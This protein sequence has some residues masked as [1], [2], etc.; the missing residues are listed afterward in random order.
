MKL[1]NKAIRYNESV[2]SKFP[3]VLRALEKGDL[4]AVDLFHT[5]KS[6]M[7]DVSDFMDILDCLFALGKIDFTENTRRLSY[8]V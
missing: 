6:S 5:V 1:P 2:L 4:S 7:E 8:V 3:I